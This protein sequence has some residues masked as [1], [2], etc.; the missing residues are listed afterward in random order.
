MVH[1]KSYVGVPHWETFLVVSPSPLSSQVSWEFISL[2]A[3]QR[4]EHVGVCVLGGVHVSAVRF[5]LFFLPAVFEHA[6]A[7]TATATSSAF[8]LLFFLL[9]ITSSMPEVEKIIW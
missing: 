9:W 4:C 1:V 5:F 8:T 3:G 7:A 2:S 6:V